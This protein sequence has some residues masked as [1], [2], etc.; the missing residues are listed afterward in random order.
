MEN[1]L[2]KALSEIR[3]DIKAK[4]DELKTANDQKADTLNKEIEALK[5]NE[6]DFETR[7]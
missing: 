2:T 5:T 3:D 4:V 7:L 1:E 6:K